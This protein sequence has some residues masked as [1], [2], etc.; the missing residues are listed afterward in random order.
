MIIC[1]FN[2]KADGCQS[3]VELALIEELS[4]VENI[5]SIF[6]RLKRLRERVEHMTGADGTYES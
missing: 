5:K 3:A 6:A 2:D 1:G 4:E